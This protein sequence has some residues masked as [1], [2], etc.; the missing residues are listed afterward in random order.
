[1]G[2]K[3]SM[4]PA[5][6]TLIA[7]PARMAS[8]RLPNKPLKLLAGL[9]VV[10]RVRRQAIKAAIGDVV[11]ATDHRDILR[12][13]E[14]YG[15]QAVMTDKS[16]ASGTDRVRSAA[17]KLE[18]RRGRRYRVIVN[19]QGDEPFISP[20]TIRK[21]A[22]LAR[23]ADISTAVVPGLKGSAARDPNTVK[24]VLT[25]KGQCLYFSR[26]PV[27]HSNGRGSELFQHIGIYGFSRP[28]LERFVRLAPSPLEKAERLEQLRALED[29]MSIYAARVRDRTIAIDTRADLSRAARRFKNSSGRGHG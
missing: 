19:L 17:Q 20:S 21:V 23:K 29:G 24:A 4:K 11:V 16:L 1:M 12:T 6:G 25:H 5:S 18:R 28:A 14:G 15:G 7:I 10:E 8:T 27:P 26:S 9:P 13:V 22:L 3:S 2:T